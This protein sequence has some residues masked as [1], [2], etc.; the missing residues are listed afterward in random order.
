MTVDD[1]PPGGTI[2]SLLDLS[3]AAL[4]E[5]RL[6]VR[7]RGEVDLTTVARLATVLHDAI[8]HTGDLV[9]LDLEQVTF[10]DSSGVGAIVVADRLARS[11]GRRLVIGPRS[12]FVTRVFEVAGLD[13][14]LTFDGPL[15]FEA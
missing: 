14:A 10:I 6:L 15:A 5:A 4:S 8:E 2:D 13:Q 3:T 1:Q 11:L 7:A 9:E 12:I